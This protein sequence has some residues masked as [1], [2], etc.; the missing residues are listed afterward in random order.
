MTTSGVNGTAPN[1]AHPPA[2]AA[3]ANTGTA[4]L[5]NTTVFLQLLVAQ[6]KNQ[7]PASPADGTQFVTQLA[8]F[9]TLEQNTQMRQDLDAIRQAL[10]TAG[11]TN[12]TAN[13]AT[14]S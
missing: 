2:N 9:S 10:A 5:A 4:S 11:A 3:A 14:H 12:N 13:Q 8:Q 6:L 1:A 7:D